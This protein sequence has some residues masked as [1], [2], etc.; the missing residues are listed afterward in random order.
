MEVSRSMSSRISLIE[1]NWSSVSS[2]SKVLANSSS[3]RP[4][5]EKA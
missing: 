3:Q 5:E 4:P 1:R 2:Y